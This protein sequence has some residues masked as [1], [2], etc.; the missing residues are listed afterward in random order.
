[1]KKA[2]APILIVLLLLMTVPRF[3]DIYRTMAF[4]TVPR[5]DYAPYLL[6]TLG[7]KPDFTVYSPYGYRIF[8]FLAAFPF[9]KLLPVYRFTNLPPVDENYLRATQALALTSYL[10]ILAACLMIFLTAKNRLRLPITVSLLAALLAY[11]LFEFTNMFAVDPLAIFLI[12]VLVYFLEQPLLFSVIVLLSVPFNEKVSLVFLMLFWV[13]LFI[14]RKAFQERWQLLITTLAAGS[15]F[16]IRTV[17]NLPGFENQTS[18]RSFWP[19]FVNTL[20][21]TLSLKGVVQNVLPIVVLLLIY[22]LAVQSLRSRQTPYF[23]RADILVLVGLTLLAFVTRLEYTVGRIVMYSF[24]LY[25][26][27]A[28]ASIG[29]YF[30]EMQGRLEGL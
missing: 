23:L 15:Y 25:L 7:E 14:Q 18:L 27:A 12:S 11:G 29:I 6:H 30:S 3:F 19:S 10:A 9:Y 21:D 1:M 26:P 17:V 20:G 8:S 22:F 13:R 5:D 24:P 2:L 4:N 16:A 28:C